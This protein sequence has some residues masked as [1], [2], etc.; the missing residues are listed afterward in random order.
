[1]YCT[2]IQGDSQQMKGGRRRYLVAVVVLDAEPR[3]FVAHDDAVKYAEIAEA[4]GDR[5]ALR[6]Q[7]DA[8][9]FARALDVIFSLRHGRCT[10]RAAL[11]GRALG[12]P[13]RAGWSGVGFRV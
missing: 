10:R 13:P 12:K 5:A 9:M 3:R 7:P 1:M 4:L 11:G 6:A 2:F 8:A